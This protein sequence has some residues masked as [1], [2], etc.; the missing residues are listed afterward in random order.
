MAT[1]LETKTS[2]DEDQVSSLKLWLKL[3]ACT[4][5]IENELRGRLRVTYNTTLP[6][7]D[8]LA[9]L[10]G[11][12]NGLRMGELSARLMVSNG[13]ITAISNQ[14]QKEGLIYKHTDDNDRRS[15]YLS[16]TEEGAELFSKMNES[17]I[18]WIDQLFDKLKEP[19]SKR[20]YKA[21]SE[22]KLALKSAVNA[23]S[24]KL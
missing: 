16:L 12:E 15:T 13:N 3:S 7:F 14:L 22:V 17:Y 24:A 5:M 23:P 9:Q 19:K 8:L 6:R 4:S 18:E 11:S 2:Q 10:N 1:N 21:L 20:S